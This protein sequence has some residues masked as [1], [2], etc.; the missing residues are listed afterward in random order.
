[1]SRKLSVILLTCFIICVVLTGCGPVEK[2]TGLFSRDEVIEVGELTE[3]RVNPGYGDMDGGY[4]CMTL[5]KDESDEWVIVSEDRDTYSAPT[6]ITTYAVTED[7]VSSFAGFLKDNNVLSL[8]NRKDSDDFIYDYHAWSYNLIYD[9]TS[10]GGS[11]YE[12][13]TISQYKEYSDKDYDL[14]N[15]IDNRFDDLRGEVISEVTERDDLEPDEA[16]FAIGSW[17][18]WKRQEYQANN[19]NNTDTEPDSENGEY[20]SESDDT[21]DEDDIYEFDS[22]NEVLYRHKEAQDRRYS[23]KQTFDLMGFFTPLIDRGWPYATMDDEVRYLYYDVNEDGE[24]EL[25]IT[26]CD[27]IAEIYGKCK[28]SYHMFYSAPY[29]ADVTLYPDG[30]LK[31]SYPEGA[32]FPGTVWQKFDPVLGYYFDEFEEY[33][34]SKNGN[35]YFVFC[36]FDLDSDGYQEIVDALDNFGSLPVWIGEYSDEITKEEYESYVPTGS[37]VKLPEGELLSSVKLPDGYEFL[38]D[39]SDKPQVSRVGTVKLNDNVQYEANVFVSNFI[40]QNINT[41]YGSYTIGA[42]SDPANLIG[43]VFRYMYINSPSDLETDGDT[44]SLY[45][46]EVNKGLDR[47]FGLSLTETQAKE[48]GITFADGKF[49]MNVQEIN[50]M[51]DFAVVRRIN[52]LDDGNYELI[53]DVFAPSSDTPDRREMSKL[54]HLN[55]QDAAVTGACTERG[56]SGTAIVRKYSYNNRNTY[57]LIRLDV[58]K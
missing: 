16:D 21:E 29:G 28:D 5:K 26:F 17:L 41:P 58:G 55:L 24:D 38:Y 32:E 2:I 43:F 31:Q 42:D 44:R 3:F 8:M 46:D 37:P 23:S 45:L 57:Q 9:N 36:Y 33:L 15:E 47:F 6:I 51:G 50:G 22:Y 54:Y 1:M 34:D 7:G 19:I 14:L 27:E 56:V 30:M 18:D 13:Y 48:S 49:T 12:T 4:H 39:P 10:I 11:S 40:E 52:E 25:I 53:F 35:Q 20:I